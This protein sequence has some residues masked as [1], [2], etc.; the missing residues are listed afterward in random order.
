MR[1]LLVDGVRALARM[2]VDGARVFGAHW[3]QLLVLF[4][5]GWAGRMGFLWAAT[6]VS[7]WSPTVAVFILPL[8][9]MSTLLSMV[10][11]LRAMAPSLSAFQG[12]VEPVSRVQRLRGDL[13]VAGQVLL[14][15]LAVYASAGLLTQD[16]R[17][18]LVDAFADESLNAQVPTMDYGRTLYAEG[19]LLVAMI[20]GALVLRKII[21]MRELTKKSAGWAAAAAYLEVLWMVTLANAMASQLA[22]LT[23]WVTSRRVVAGVLDW[24]E[25]AV[26]M[27]REWGGWATTLLDTVTGFLGSLGS[28]VIVPVA[29]LAIGASVYG[30]QLK[31]SVLKVETPEE[32]D[33]RQK[34]LPPVRRA[35]ARATEPVA[36]PVRSAMRALAKI[37]SAGVVPMA[38]FC[39][40]F[41]VAA[42]V[43]TFVA[44]GMRLLIGPG[45]A[46]RQY[47]M[48]PYA[49]MAERGVYF[50]VVLVLLAVA[51]NVV[52]ES[53]REP[54]APEPAPEPSGDVQH[55]V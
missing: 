49:V 1:Q 31:S 30:Q 3:P 45:Q 27:A 23:E 44:Q 17:V 51:V 9:P 18:F 50:V 15:F 55:Q 54:A 47:A 19:W 22:Q 12:L 20:V 6:A 35:M 7:D 41:A 4:L 46:L 39:V 32:I 53:Q 10:L 38:L 42:Q 52:V 48:E 13:T 36:S 8:A 11:M 33:A 37:A 29:W 16:V 40:A 21:T 28:L 26:G 43:Q 34:K 25:R 14:P 5:A 2:F 24:Y